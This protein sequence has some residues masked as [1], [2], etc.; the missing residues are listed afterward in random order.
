MSCQGFI[1]GSELSILSP[2]FNL[3]ASFLSLGMGLEAILD[4]AF[5]TEFGHELRCLRREACHSFPAI[6]LQSL[7]FLSGVFLISYLSKFARGIGDYSVS[8][9]AIEWS[10]KTNLINSIDRMQVQIEPCI[11]SQVQD[12]ESIKGIRFRHRHGK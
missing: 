12:A 4:G 1:L 10:H 9:G 3:H 11:R 7:L 5:H 2:V 6:V 8:T